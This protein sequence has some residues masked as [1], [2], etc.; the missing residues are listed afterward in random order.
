MNS[1]A[2]QVPEQI[3]HCRQSL[4]GLPCVAYI[5]FAISLLK[6]S[7]ILMN[8]PPFIPGFST[9]SLPP[10]ATARLPFPAEI[11]APPVFQ[12][13][14]GLNEMGMNGLAG[15]EKSNLFPDAGD[16]QYWHLFKLRILSD[17]PRQSNALRSATHHDVEQEQVVVFRLQGLKP[18]LWVI[19]HVHA[20]VGFLKDGLYPCNKIGIV[21]NH[22]YFGI[23]RM[24]PS[25][26]IS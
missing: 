18:I 3:P 19:R 11:S 4:I 17:L 5:R 1:A 24:S 22:H 13:L 12:Q 23:H 7:S 2:G 10:G 25:I 14:I 26:I 6:D 16:D 15:E 8:S 9:F 20:V 21:V